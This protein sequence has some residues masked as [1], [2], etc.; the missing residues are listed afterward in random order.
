MERSEQTAAVTLNIDVGE[1]EV[2]EG[3]KS[4]RSGRG[5]D[6]RDATVEEERTQE[7][8]LLSISHQ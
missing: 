6:A 4:R 1:M 3:K 7:M 5:K 2:D 8:R